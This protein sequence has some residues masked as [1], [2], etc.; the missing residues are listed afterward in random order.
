[1]QLIVRVAV[2]VGL[3]VIFFLEGGPHGEGKEKDADGTEDNGDDDNDGFSGGFHEYGGW[4][5]G[6][7][8][9]GWV[10]GLS[11]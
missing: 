4:N 9:A 10:H 6:D 7:W 2:G 3:R 5:I 1:M 11:Y 8:V